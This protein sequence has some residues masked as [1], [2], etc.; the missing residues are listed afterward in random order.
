MDSIG[1]DSRTQKK[2]LGS[3]YTPPHLAKLI[4]YDSLDS[5][6]HN[7]SD[8]D[9]KSQLELVQN[10]KILD[11][12]V[13]AGVF[14][15]AT[16]NWLDSTRQRLGDKLGTKKRRELIVCNSLFGVDI[17]DIAVT[18]CRSEIIRWFSP[19]ADEQ[20]TIIDSVNANIRQGNSLT[21]YNWTK[22]FSKIITRK[23]SGF[24]IILGNPP[25]GNILNKDERD[26]IQTNYP[27]N[28]GGNRAGTWNSAAHFIVRASMLLRQ[29]GELAFL[30][31]N[32]ILRVKQFRKTRQ[33]LLEHLKLW[34]IVDEGSP[35]DDVTLEM[36][37]IFCAKK[38]HENDFDVKV[39]SRRPG[40]EQKN[41]V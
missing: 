7:R 22:N 6:L 35:F 17:E 18:S 2:K 40:F 8:I 25:Y 31:P 13:G 23:N 33:F 26:F 1:S 28:V 19:K 14:L 11:P 9:R 29:D 41:S 24:D 36:V 4:T 12:S 32:S 37:T 27:F 16:A 10:L 20:R 21:S 3:F 15:I 5:W 34:K 30:I 38:K 39:E